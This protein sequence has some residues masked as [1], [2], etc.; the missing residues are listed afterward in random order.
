MTFS[1][2]LNTLIAEKGIDLEQG[3]EVEGASGTNHMSYGIVV[4]AI[5]GAPKHEQAGIKT[6]IVKIDFH[7]GDVRHFLRH[8][9]QA[10]AI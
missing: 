4:A 1:N 5:K 2:W 7:N 9:A 3:F 6:T 10:I 8:L